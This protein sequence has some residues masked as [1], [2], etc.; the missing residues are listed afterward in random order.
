MRN[1]KERGMSTLADRYQ[2]IREIALV[3]LMREQ[4][5]EALV[6]PYLKWQLLEADPLTGD[7]LIC[8]PATAPD[9]AEI[10]DMLL[11]RGIIGTLWTQERKTHLTLKRAYSRKP[12][13][14]NS[15]R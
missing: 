6:R 15:R 9:Q 3:H 8:H 5:L 14:A 11:L 4:N 13:F 10:A 2:G 1:K 12:R 7:I